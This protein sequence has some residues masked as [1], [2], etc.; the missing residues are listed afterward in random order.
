[1]PSKW[2]FAM[3]REMLVYLK[4]WTEQIVLIFL[5]LSDEQ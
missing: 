3:T 2:A 5:G 4:L 1:M